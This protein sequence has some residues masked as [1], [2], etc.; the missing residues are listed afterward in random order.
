VSAL[1]KAS[2]VRL[3]PAAIPPII[4]K[5]NQDHRPARLKKKVPLYHMYIMI[6]IVH[7]IA[8]D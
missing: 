4:D 6:A 5:Y 3:T 8:A 7:G 2:L 1:K